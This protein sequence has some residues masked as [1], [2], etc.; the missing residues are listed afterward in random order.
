MIN[1]YA[2]HLGGLGICGVNAIIRI[3]EYI[4]KEIGVETGEYVDFCNSLHIYGKDLYLVKE[5]LE[6]LNLIKKN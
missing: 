5:F 4:A 3:Q 2:K 1:L 6:Q